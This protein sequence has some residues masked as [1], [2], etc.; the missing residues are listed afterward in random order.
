M[1]FAR[2]S[3]QQRNVFFVEISTESYR[4]NCFMNHSPLGRL[5]RLGEIRTREASSRTHLPLPKTNT[6]AHSSSLIGT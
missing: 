5:P 2:G 3:L 4:S 6:F 1:S